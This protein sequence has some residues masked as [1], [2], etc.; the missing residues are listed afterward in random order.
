[1]ILFNDIRNKLENNKLVSNSKMKTGITEKQILILRRSQ[2]VQ[3]L[4]SLYKDFLIELGQDTG[5]FLQNWYVTYSWI[6]T[7]K[8]EIISRYFNKFKVE[9]EIF[10][11]ASSDRKFTNFLYFETDEKIND[12]VVY[13][14]NS[15]ASEISLY[16]DNLSSFYIHELEKLDIR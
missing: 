12:P 14:Y 11:F 10:V 1:M 3:Y 9:K 13:I 2:C 5:K 15:A 16:F 6:L 4:P 8:Q 7:A